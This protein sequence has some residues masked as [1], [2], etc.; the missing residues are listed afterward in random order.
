[1]PPSGGARGCRP[2]GRRVSI[3]GCWHPVCQRDPMHTACEA[4][5]P[6]TLSQHYHAAQSLSPKAAR[7]AARLLDGAPDIPFEWRLSLRM[8]LMERGRTAASFTTTDLAPIS[9]DEADGPRAETRPQD[10]AQRFVLAV[11]GDSSPHG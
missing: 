11:Q 1:M 9:S 4:L 8:A 2:A 5:P 10:Q 3:R 7:L 6:M